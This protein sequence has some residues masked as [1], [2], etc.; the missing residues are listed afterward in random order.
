VIV[1]AP[2]RTIG[3]AA[4]AYEP[5]RLFLLSLLIGPGC[6]GRTAKDDD[7]GGEPPRELG[8]GCRAYYEAALGCY[9]QY[10]DTGYTYETSG[11]YPYEPGSYCD[12]LETYF[13]EYYGEPCA[14]AYD[15]MFACLAELDCTTLGSTF[16]EACPDAWERGNEACPG[17][18]PACEC[19][20]Y[21]SSDGMCGSECDTCLDGNRY[22]V[23]CME[24]ASDGTS[25]CTCTV[26][27]EV[28]QTFTDVV[29]PCNDFETIQ[30]DRCMIP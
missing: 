10:S 24:I 23:E 9:E 21:F 22:A 25:T 13:T 27:G 4:M 12:Y 28:E 18:F 11:G 7:D 1:Y 26:N 19:S 20:E 8:D 5:E 30:H 6:V 14:R 15:D 3:S 29:D 2:W 16:F 17:L